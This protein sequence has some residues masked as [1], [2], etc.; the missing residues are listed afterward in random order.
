MNRLLIIMFIIALFCHLFFKGE[1]YNFK[2]Y[3]QVLEEMD[4]TA[5]LAAIITAE[6]SICS[7][8]EKRLIA[9]VVINRVRSDKY[10]NSIKAVLSQNKQFY[11]YGS[12]W[13]KGT[14]ESTY[15]AKE[16]MSGGVVDSNIIYFFN[17]KTST[18]GFVRHIN[19]LHKEEHHW[20]GVDF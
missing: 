8:R 11:G 7:D 16:I 3:E 18:A 19:I 2:T 1:D 20:F 17:P 14:K 5:H 10:P 6:C 15:I 4:D 9:S 12:R 13:Y